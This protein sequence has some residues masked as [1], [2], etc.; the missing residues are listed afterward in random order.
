MGD[1]HLYELERASYHVG[2]SIFSGWRK[3]HSGCKEVTSPTLPLGSADQLTAVSTSVEPSGNTLL[4]YNY[5][6]FSR[7]TSPLVKSGEGWWRVSDTLHP[8][9]HLTIRHLYLIGEGWRAFLKVAFYPPPPE[10]SIHSS[11]LRVQGY[12]ITS[13]IPH[14]R[15]RNLLVRQKNFIIFS[16][17]TNYYIVHTNL[18]CITSHNNSNSPIHFWGYNITFLP[19]FLEGYIYW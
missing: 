17:S 18:H 15:H 3:Y 4:S 10:S 11:Q 2:K 7:T 13:I 19:L 16:I 6:P 14:Y 5:N 8:Y 1:R 9:K 12:E